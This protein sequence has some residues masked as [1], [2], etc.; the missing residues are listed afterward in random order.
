[1]PIDIL[2]RPDGK[3]NHTGASL[4][5]CVCRA[6]IWRSI[7]RF[8]IPYSRWTC[9]G[10]NAGLVSAGAWTHSA[11]AASH[12]TDF[13]LKAKYLCR[14]A[15]THSSMAASSQRTDRT[16][17]IRKSVFAL[18]IDEPLVDHPASSRTHRIWWPRG[19]SAFGCPLEHFLLDHPAGG[20]ARV[21]WG[22][23]PNL[24]LKARAGGRVGC[25]SYCPC[26]WPQ[27]V[28]PGRQLL[29]MTELDGPLQVCTPQYHSSQSDNCVCVSWVGVK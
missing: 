28:A 15:W 25:G 24:A 20:R 5:I 22:R 4:N 7:Y 26:T 10:T 3:T 1:L 19:S 17:S 18:S 23:L 13:A 29:P 2:G 8:A 27:W 11:C 12:R 6:N 21:F 16:S 14:G 9:L